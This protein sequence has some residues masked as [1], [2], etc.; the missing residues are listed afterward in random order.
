MTSQVDFGYPW[1]LAYGHLVV[2]AVLLP[3]FLLARARKWSRALVILIGAA[4]LW[5]AAAFVVA[6]FVIGVNSRGVLPTEAFLR[7]GAGRVLD[8]GAGTGRS[9]LMVLEARPQATVVALDQ[10]GASYERHFG[11]KQ[12]GE[13]RLLANL[14][15][16]GVEQRATIQRGDMRQLPFQAAEFDAIITAYVVDHLSRDGVTASLSEASRVLKPGG[17]FLMMI[18]GKE[19]WVTFAFGPLLLHHGARNAERWTSLLEA[20]G[21]RVVEQGFRP[22]TLFLLARKAG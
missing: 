4:A 14:R 19:P 11:S 15:A 3:L 20:A 16:A 5:S 17:D 8:L 9:T 21:L 12:T 6:R 7:S 18:V 10:F 13:E 22:A 1:F 2:L